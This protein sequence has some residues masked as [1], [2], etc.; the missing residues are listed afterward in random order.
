VSPVQG[1]IPPSFPTPRSNRIRDCVFAAGAAAWG[2]SMWAVHVQ[3]RSYDAPS[4]GAGGVFSETFE[5]DLRMGLRVSGPGVL[6][7]GE[8]VRRTREPYEGRLVIEEKARAEGSLLGQGVL[9]EFEV[10]SRWEAPPPGSAH[11]REHGGFRMAEIRTRAFVAGLFDEDI[12]ATATRSGDVLVVNITRAAS[13]AP[14]VRTIRLPPG[15]DLSAGLMDAA[16][17]SPLHVGAR[18]TTHSVGLSGELVAAEVEVVERTQV[19]VAGVNTS[20]FRAVTRVRGALPQ[21][22]ELSTWYDM[23][24]RALKQEIP[25]GPMTLEIERLERLPAGE[26]PLPEDSPTPV[27][28][29]PSGSARAGHAQGQGHSILP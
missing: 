3:G 2:L 29:V 16:G 20:G 27:P 17:A 1:S 15:A 18:W 8:G 5:R 21:R 7:V 23:E 25:L 22:R 6:L 11:A 19:A 9:V 13:A 26:T 28:P 10:V 12:H 24:G 14:L 4:G